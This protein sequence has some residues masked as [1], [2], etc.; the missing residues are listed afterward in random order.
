[1]AQARYKV[2][3]DRHVRPPADEISVGSFVFL[4]R[5][6]PVQGSRNK[7]SSKVTGPYK[8]IKRSSHTETI[9][10]AAGNEDTVSLD[11]VTF[12]PMADNELSSEPLRGDGTSPRRAENTVQE[13][14]EDFVFDRVVWTFHSGNSGTSTTSRVM[15]AQL[16]LSSMHD[17]P[18]Q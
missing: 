15:V 18:I 1:M 5:E 9:I 11:R 13:E 6:A 12:A 17:L 8:V 2:D 16:K 3:F 14:G 4:L 7:L 10:I